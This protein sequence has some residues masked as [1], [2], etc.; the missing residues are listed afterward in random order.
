MPP[1]HLLLD[2]NV[3]AAYYLPRST[4]SVHVR[5]R[6]K[7]NVDSVR[8]GHSSFF[9]YLP[10]FCVAEVFSVIMKYSFGSWNRHVRGRTFDT[11][12]YRESQLQIYRLALH[13]R[14]SPVYLVR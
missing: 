12:I 6:I 9:F 14:A 4:G 1:R 2:A 5:E 13:L 7:T 3:V 8:S 10:N 11:R